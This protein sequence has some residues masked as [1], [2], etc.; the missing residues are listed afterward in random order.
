MS[1]EGLSKHDIG[2]KYLSRWLQDQLSAAAQAPN[3]KVMGGDS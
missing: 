2:W 1:R 3:V